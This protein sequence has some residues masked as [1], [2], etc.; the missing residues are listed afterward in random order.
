M[1]S[2]GDDENIVP[3]EFLDVKS[4]PMDEDLD[5][6]NEDEDYHPGDDF[7]SG[8]RHRSSKC[9]G[10]TPDIRKKKKELMDEKNL[11]EDSINVQCYY[12]GDMLLL[13][14][15]TEHMREKHGR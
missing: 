9:K 3:Q 12:C 13:N 8:S 11:D 10:D 14:S 15:I 6:G 7:N 1:G 5:D 2:E 4:E